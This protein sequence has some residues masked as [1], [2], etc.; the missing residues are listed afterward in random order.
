MTDLVIERRFDASAETVFAFLTQPDKIATWWGPEGMTCPVLD[1]NLA[2]TGDWMSVMANADGGRFKVSGV[3]E[4]VSPPHR[5]SFTWGWHDENDRRGPESRVTFEVT[6]VAEGGTVFKLTH[7][8]LPDEESAG[9]HN[10]GW[11]SSLRKL[12]AALT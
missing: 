6:P 7:A 9:N 5:V 12:E 8:D 2:Q 4:D 3:V 10:Q 11:T 1:M